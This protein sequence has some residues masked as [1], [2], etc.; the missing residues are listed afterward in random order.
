MDALTA[1]ATRSHE[2]REMRGLLN[3][4]LDMLAVIAR[5]MPDGSSLKRALHAEIDAMRSAANAIQ[6][7]DGVPLGSK[8]VI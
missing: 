3:T 8:V 2:V 4:A 5:P 6:S 7:R 1:P